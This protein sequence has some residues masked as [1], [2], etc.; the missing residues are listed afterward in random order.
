MPLNMP[1]R[2]M[3]NP[4]RYLKKLPI[5]ITLIKIEVYS[6]LM[7]STS[8]IKSEARKKQKTISFTNQIK[9]F[10]LSVLYSPTLPTK[11]PES[12]TPPFQLLQRLRTPYS[13]KYITKK[14]ECH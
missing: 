8:L 4:N 12:T 11:K 3:Q 10:L 6:T 1:I 7:D 5:K 13:K 9:R 14:N 2:S